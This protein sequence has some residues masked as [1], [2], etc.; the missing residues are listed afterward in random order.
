MTCLPP[1]FVVGMGRSGTTLLRMMLTHHPRLA[2][3]Y[4]S[5]FLT[6]FEDEAGRFAPLDADENLRRLVEAMLAEPN[7][8][9]WDHRFTLEEILSAVTHR[10]VAGVADTIYGRYAAAKGKAR[11]GDKS[12]YLDRMHVLYR[13]FPR[14]QFIHI[15]RDGRDVALSVLKLAWGPNDVV[16]AAEWW[17]AHVA[18]ARRVGAVMGPE[19]YME[20]LY[21]R[22][23]E[24]PE[25]ELR[26]CCAFLNEAYSP[27][28]L[29]YAAGAPSAIPADTRSL[30]HGVDTAPYRTRV[31]AW[32]REMK[33]VDVALFDRHAH[34]TLAELGYEVPALDVPLP[35][36]AMRYLMLVGRRLL[37]ARTAA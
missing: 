15:V 9:R 2:I 23:V 30:H 28:M 10:S 8:R 12:D 16:R 13:M 17:D 3:P 25:R 35:R 33:P 27:S 14:A 22:L 32:K 6:R 24:D 20:V 5:G 29:E 34:R 26:R 37:E 1:F 21:E 18:M 31:Y 36:L 4:E 19:R 7:L 11:W